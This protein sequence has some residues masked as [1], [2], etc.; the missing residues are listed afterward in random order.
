M[1]GWDNDS[2]DATGN[3]AGMLVVIMVILVEVLA[4]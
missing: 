1:I 4:I 3:N 2:G